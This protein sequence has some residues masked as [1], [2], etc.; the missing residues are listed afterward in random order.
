MGAVVI[1]LCAW[2]YGF[3][4][5]MVLAAIFGWTLIALAFIDLDTGYLPDALTLPL[6]VGGVAF[7]TVDLFAPWPHAIFGAV[8][9]YWAFWLV[10]K[11][12]KRW[13]GY[14]GLGLGDAKLLSAIGAWTGWQLLP[15]AVFLAAAT[16]LLVVVVQS[17]PKGGPDKKQEIPFGPGLAAAGF[18]A[19]MWT[20]FA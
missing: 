1:L 18:A 9:G 19:L 4:V 11:A 8:I 6:I 5:E 10:G 14:E 2:R 12:F 15:A 13:R 16:T 20:T 7:N 17:A 3:G